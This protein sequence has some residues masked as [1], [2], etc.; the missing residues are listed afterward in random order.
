MF[1]FSFISKLYLTIGICLGKIKRSMIE[2]KIQDFNRWSAEHRKWAGKFKR[3]LKTKD[4]SLQSYTTTLNLFEVV[5]S[6]CDQIAVE[7]DESS[8]EL[9]KILRNIQKHEKGSV[10]AKLAQERSMVNEAKRDLDALENEQRRIK[11]NLDRTRKDL[12]NARL[13][14]RKHY[15]L[16]E[17]QKSL[18]EDRKELKQQIKNRRE[19]YRQ[20]Q[21]QY[22]TNTENIYQDSQKKEFTRLKTMPE[23]LKD[24][25][26]VLKIDPTLL[27]DAIENHNPET[28]LTSWKKSHF[29]SS[30]K[31]NSSLIQ[32]Y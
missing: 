21:K 12:G 29:S 10:K 26:K 1:N 3:S 8:K 22:L 15:K 4:P 28:D 11:E 6:L 19:T 9:E 32:E 5:I 17:N 30:F 20:A 31:Q 13:N 18:L 23:S 24:F 16:K 27:K 2:E 25:V 14:S 7:F